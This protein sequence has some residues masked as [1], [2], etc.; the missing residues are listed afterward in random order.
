MLVKRLDA[1]AS[2]FV[3][4]Q[5][6][7]ANNQLKLDNNEASSANQGAW[8][9]T[10]PTASVFTIGTADSV[11]ASNGTYVAYLFG[12]VQGFS[13]MG[14]YLGNGSADGAFIYTGFK[15]T[16]FMT[17]RTNTSGSDWSMWG[18]TSLSGFNSIGRR[19]FPNT[20]GAES[21]QDS[22]PMADFLSNGVKIR[23]TD[24]DYNGDDNTYIYMAFAEN[25]FISAAGIPVTAR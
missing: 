4:H 17:K 7:G 22:S 5:K 12:D 13:K 24:G 25:P 23:Q 18:Y 19:L 15:P 2:W 1:A 6:L 14:S 3:Y 9:N 20:S 11:N 8:N 21:S 10:T 16:F